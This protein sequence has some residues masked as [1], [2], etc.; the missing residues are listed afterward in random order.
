VAVRVA[1]TRLV[2]DILAA[3]HRGRRPAGLLRSTWNGSARSAI[4]WAG[5]PRRRQ[6]S[7]TGGSSPVPTWTGWSWTRSRPGGWTARS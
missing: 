1:D 5:P 4:P 7:R 2:L 3:L 6:C